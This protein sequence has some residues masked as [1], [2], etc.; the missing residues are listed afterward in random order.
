MSAKI[1]V[2]LITN[3]PMLVLSMKLSITASVP[4]F[5]QVLLSIVI[6]FV[7]KVL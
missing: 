1:G 5:K 4:M 6:H 3:A 7:K 2:I